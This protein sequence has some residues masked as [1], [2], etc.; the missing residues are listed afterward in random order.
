MVHKILV[1]LSDTQ[2]ERLQKLKDFGDSD[3]EKLR[4]I[5]IAFLSEKGYLTQKPQEED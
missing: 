3:A 5:F 2:Y 4:N 1:T